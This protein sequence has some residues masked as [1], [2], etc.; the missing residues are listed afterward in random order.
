MTYVWF[1]PDADKT[2]SRTLQGVRLTLNARGEPVIWEVLRD[3]SGAHLVFAAQSLETAARKAFGPPLPGR[4]FAVENDIAESP[5]VVVARVIDDGPVPMGPVVH[6]RAGTENVATLICRCM[7]VQ[8]RQVV[9]NE[10]YELRPLSALR[11]KMAL[12]QCAWPSPPTGQCL[13]LPPEF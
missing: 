12:P 9:T 5:R 13:R 6:L 4:R 8:T 10:L 1:S 2:P 11:G 3:N 7:T